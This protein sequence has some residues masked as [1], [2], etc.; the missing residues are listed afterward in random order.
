MA[1][2]EKFTIHLRKCE[3]IAYFCRPNLRKG[4]VAEW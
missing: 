3:D 2:R 1:K 4:E